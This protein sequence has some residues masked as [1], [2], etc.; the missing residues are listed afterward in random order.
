MVQII[1]ITSDLYD[2]VLSFKKRKGEAHHQIGSSTKNQPVSF[3]DRDRF[4]IVLLGFFVFWLPWI[5][6][7]RIMFL[8]HYSPSVP[9]LCL[10]LGYQID[11]MLRLKKSRY[12][13]FTIL[14]LVVVGFLIVYPMITGVPLSREWFTKFFDF[15]L[16]KN[17]F[18][19]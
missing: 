19:Q 10:S 17:P 16:T 7:P 12:I 1:K 13:G 4:L 2:F 8:Y 15:N 5:F 9:F 18:G 3:T 11:L 14:A 6:S